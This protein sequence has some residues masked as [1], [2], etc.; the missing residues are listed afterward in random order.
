MLVRRSLLRQCRALQICRQPALS[1]GIIRPS[2]AYR[3]FH[4]YRAVRQEKTPDSPAEAASTE[5]KSDQPEQS[6]D[7][8]SSAEKPADSTAQAAPKEPP[9]PP[10][11]RD[12]DPK[13]Q[14]LADLKVVIN[15][16]D[17]TTG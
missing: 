4:V 17:L 16:L 3:P 1:Y 10:P 15:K 8:G 12:V 9:P 14:E 6:A 11:K 13:D 7:N 5:Q 2:S